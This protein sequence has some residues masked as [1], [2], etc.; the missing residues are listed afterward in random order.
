MGVK[1]L[2]KLI[3]ATAPIAIRNVHLSEYRGLKIAVDCN[4]LLYQFM[5]GVTK[6]GN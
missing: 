2:Y 5:C 6:Q 3:E 1:K 4:Q